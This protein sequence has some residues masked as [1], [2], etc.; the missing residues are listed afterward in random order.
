MIPD[1]FLGLCDDAAL[2]PP[3]N[4][5]L[6][7]ALSEHL[8]HLDSG[9]ADLVGP[10]V[11]PIPRLRELT[12]PPRPIRL[13]LTAPGGPGTVRA[14]LEQVSGIDGLTVVAVEVALPEGASPDELAPLGLLDGSIDVHVEIPRDARRLRVLD[15]VADLG[16]RAKLRTGGVTAEAHPDEAEL[17]DVIQEA[18]RRGVAF[19]ATA[20]LHHAVRNTGRDNRFEQHGYLNV[21]LAAQSAA[22]GAGPDELA[23]LLANRDSGDIVSRIARV[24]APRS[25]LSFGTCSIQE[26]L[27]DLTAL[28]LLPTPSAPPEGISTP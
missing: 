15:V 16:A 24:S 14:A 20:G 11:F 3:G 18:S 19:K 5:P 28:G 27:D 25:L 1:L 22:E 10:F 13:S 2:F 26:P 7:R 21:L 17:A 4:A 6:G 8:E 9:H 23:A 12:T